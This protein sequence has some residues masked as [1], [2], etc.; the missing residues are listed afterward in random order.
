MPGLKASVRH[1][2]HTPRTQKQRSRPTPSSKTP[3][4]PADPKSFCLISYLA[5]SVKK[6]KQFRSIM[7]HGHS[8][9]LMPLSSPESTRTNDVDKIMRHLHWQLAVRYA[10]PGC[11]HE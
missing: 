6:L 3:V 2:Q 8:S 11:Q 5:M 1:G 4:S 9:H 10:L 7:Q